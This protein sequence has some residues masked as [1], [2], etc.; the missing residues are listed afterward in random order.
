VTQQHLITSHS[1]ITWHYWK[2]TICII[3]LYGLDDDECHRTGNIVMNRMSKH[4]EKVEAAITELL[5]VAE[6]AKSGEACLS[7]MDDVLATLNAATVQLKSQWKKVQG[8]RKIQY[9]SYNG[10]C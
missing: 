10:L 4:R 8:K 1:M 3:K 7:V 5:S 9:F 6:G 2:E